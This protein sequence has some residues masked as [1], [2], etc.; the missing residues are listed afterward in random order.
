MRLPYRPP[1]DRG[2][3]PGGLTFRRVAHAGRLP[4]ITDRQPAIE[5]A[6]RLLERRQPSTRRKTRELGALHGEVDAGILL[7]EA[8]F[9]G[10]SPPSVASSFSTSVALECP[11]GALR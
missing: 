1:S 6:Q 5:L 2:S 10:V 9:F 3:P 8:D 4:A 7:A 11:I